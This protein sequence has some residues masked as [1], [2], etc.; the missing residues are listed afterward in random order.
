MPG[1]KNVHFMPT[2]SPAG[3]RARPVRASTKALKKGCRHLLPKLGAHFVH[4]LHNC[5]FHAACSARAAANLYL[6]DLMIDLPTMVGLNQGWPE[7]K[8]GPGHRTHR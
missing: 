3:E 4:F 8:K 6:V 7:T 5:Y 2:F 1:T